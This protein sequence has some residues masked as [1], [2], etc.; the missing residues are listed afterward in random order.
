MGANGVGRTKLIANGTVVTADGEFAGDV[1]IDGEKI[2]AVGRVE[3]P[4]GTEVVDAAG[5]F[6]LPGLIDNHTHLS[7]PFM[8]M[9]SSDD[10]NTG[11]QAAAAGGTTCLVDFAIQRQPEDLQSAFDEWRGRADGAAH[12]DY[13]FH[14]AITNANESVLDDMTAMSEAGVCSFKLFMAYK[15]ALMVRDDELAACMERARDLNALTMVHAE[16]GDII[17]LLVKRAL[18]RGDTSA[19][20]HALTRPEY[21]EAE[22]TGRAATIAEHLDAP[23]FVVHV[24]CAAAA[25]E[26]EAAQQRGAPVTGE[27]CFQYLTNGIDDLRRPGVEGCRYIC[28]PPLREVSNHEPLW[29]YIR[30][31]V[32]ESVSTDHCPFNS[33]QKAHGLDDFSVVPNGLAL[34]Q[35]RLSKLW[36]EGVVTGRI[37]RS[38]LVDRTSTTIAR[39]FGLRD[40]GAL[41]PGKD[42]DVVVLDPAAPR[43][44]GTD[45]SFMN[46]DYDLYEGEMASA[47]VRHTFSRGTL[48]Y[49]RGEIKTPPGHGRFVARTLGQSAS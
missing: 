45:T 31:G 2:A 18:A 12:V 20:H 28:S 24:T 15:G 5:C 46:V 13:G 8:G 47:S 32:L 29:G 48:V 25:A 19:I 17:D 49:D 26:I 4:D 30:R 43:A 38:Q 23:L 7:M 22:A 36:D 37:T 14:M 11:T 39:R 44:Y 10:Y 9:M 42:A 1:L 34:I 3:T 35:H 27:T 41:A 40:K 16:N 21:V 33:E 6:V